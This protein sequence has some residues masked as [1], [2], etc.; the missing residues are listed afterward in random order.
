MSI[1]QAYNIGEVFKFLAITHALHGMI[2]QKLTYPVFS[3]EMFT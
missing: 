1:A 3:Q 2:I